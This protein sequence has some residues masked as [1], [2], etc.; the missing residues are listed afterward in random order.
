MFA[1]LDGLMKIRPFVPNDTNEQ[2]ETAH[3]DQESEK[4]LVHY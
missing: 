3:D 1:P 2:G 4:S